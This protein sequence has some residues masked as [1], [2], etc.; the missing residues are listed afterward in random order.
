MA[1][2]KVV[3]I[4]KVNETI[5]WPDDELENLNYENL[6]C[7]LDPGQA[8]NASI[9]EIVSVKKNGEDYYY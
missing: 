2:I 5:D 7:N 8:E 6:E 4:V 9:T 1:K 3:Y